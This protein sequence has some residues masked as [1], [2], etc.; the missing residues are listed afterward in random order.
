[1]GHLLILFLLDFSAVTV[2]QNLDE[3]RGLWQANTSFE[4][5]AAIYYTP[6]ARF[7]EPGQDERIGPAGLV[8]KFL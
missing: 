5:V 4:D 3:L 8:S 6:G 7:Y 2:N 1:M